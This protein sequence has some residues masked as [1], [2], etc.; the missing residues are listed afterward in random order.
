MTIEQFRSALSTDPFRP[1]TLR[2]VSGASFTITTPAAVL[3]LPPGLTAVIAT[4]NDSFTVIDLGKV[5]AF[6]VARP[7]LSQ[8]AKPSA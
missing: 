2:M 3:Q 4:G 5:E 8:V 6:E 1:F 7:R